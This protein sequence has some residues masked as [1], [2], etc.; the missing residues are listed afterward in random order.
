MR[1]LIGLL[2]ALNLGVLLA[3]L[4]LH[5]WPAS[6]SPTAS[7]NAD[8]IRLMAQSAPT[9][10]ATVPGEAVDSAAG[11]PATQA[12]V[13]SAEATPPL[14]RCLQWSTL[15]EPV[16][17]ALERHLQQAGLALEDY[18]IVLERTLGWWVYLPP[19]N[20]TAAA[21]ARTEQ[22]TRLGVT[23]FALVRGGA[24][25]N[26]VS[27]GAFA[28]LAQA[29]LHLNNLSRKGVRDMQYGPRPETGVAR[30]SFSQNLS[31]ERLD[32]LLET[33]PDALQARPCSPALD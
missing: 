19:S 14:S 5:F 31:Q 1:K 22:L 7:F 15:D 25:R 3:G 11:L 24:L 12:V 27:L 18:D 26:A 2:L 21:Q 28:R 33:W 32:K 30:L 8:K 9:K 13:E 20:D 17:L 4:A 29:R 6:V 10:P 16:F 23:D